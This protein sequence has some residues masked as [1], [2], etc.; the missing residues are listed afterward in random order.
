MPTK[1]KG[2]FSSVNLYVSL[3][4]FSLFTV[5]LSRNYHIHDPNNCTS[6][7]HAFPVQRLYD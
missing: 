1:D 5:H 7:I 6:T 2:S 3:T 4:A